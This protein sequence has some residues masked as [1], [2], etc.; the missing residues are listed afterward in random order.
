VVPNPYY[1]YSGYESSGLDTRVR[2]TN[3]PPVC[4]ITIF[5]LNGTLVKVINVSKAAATSTYTTISD[6]AYTTTYTTYVDW[7]LQNQ[8]NVPIASGMYLIHVDVPNVGQVTLKWFGVMRPLD[9]TSY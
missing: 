1:A 7:D 3:L 5:T 8:Y 4:T 6:P 9:L 2:I